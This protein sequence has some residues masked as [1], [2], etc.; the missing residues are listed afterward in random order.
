M[1]GG[2]SLAIA[3]EPR[4]PAVP[5]GQEQKCL[6]EL[7]AA[8]KEEKNK[9]QR[10]GTEKFN[11]ELR[12]LVPAPGAHADLGLLLVP[13]GPARLHA[14]HQPR[15]AA[16]GAAPCCPQPLLSVLGAGRALVWGQSWARATSPRASTARPL[17]GAGWWLCPAPLQPGQCKQEIKGL[18]FPSW[19]GDQAQGEADMA[20]WGPS[21][22]L[23]VLRGKPRSPATASSSSV[24]GRAPK[25]PAARKPEL[26]ELHSWSTQH[27][28]APHLLRVLEQVLEEEKRIDNENKAA[29]KKKSQSAR[30]AI[31]VTAAIPQRNQGPSPRGA[32]HLRPEDST[33]G[34]QPARGRHPAR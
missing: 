14:H 16:P 17:P 5:Q 10:Y 22:P 23:Q 11:P 8:S 7:P 20:V 12:F 27:L 33:S 1:P 31:R 18:E 32:N 2:G 4:V 28:L 6:C 15:R 3:G 19:E 21:T 30:A 26:P 9:S 25:E 29:S 13:G 24:K 34:A